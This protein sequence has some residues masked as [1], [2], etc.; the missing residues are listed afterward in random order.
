MKTLGSIKMLLAVAAVLLSGLCLLPPALANIYA[1]TASDGT[2]SLSNVPPDDHYAILIPAPVE[3]TVAAG[4]PPSSIARK[5]DYDKVVDAVART[6][7]LES[8]L[9][10]AVI[11]VESRYRPDA[12]S[13]KGAAGLMQLMPSITRHYGVSDPFDP[14]QNLHGGAKYLRYLLQAYNNDVSLALAAYNAGETAV[15]KYGNRIPPYRETV[16]YVPRVLGFYRKYR[17]ESL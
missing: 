7:G 4:D 15:A 3:R 5:V 1:Y 14:V 8:A 10:H 2:V 12:V 17:A 11:S 13:R 16:K 9:L 6:Y